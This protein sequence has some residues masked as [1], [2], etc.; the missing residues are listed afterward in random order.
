MTFGSHS[1]TAGRYNGYRF[2]RIKC[3]QHESIGNNTNIRAESHELDFII[4]GFKN[5]AN[6][7]N[8][9]LLIFA[10]REIICA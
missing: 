10:I 8:K 6:V 5:N 4:I 9:N 7:S 1:G 3:L 2:F